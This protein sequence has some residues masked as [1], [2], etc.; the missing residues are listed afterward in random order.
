MLVMQRNSTGPPSYPRLQA[1]VYFTKLGGLGLF[2]RRRRGLEPALGGVR[3]YTD[4]ET[5][6]GSRLEIEI[7]LPDGTT[8]ICKV[9]VVRVELLPPG[10]PA[11]YDVGLC[12]IAIHPHDRER[13][14]PVLKQG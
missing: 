4:E 1:P 10:S 11:T 2:R 13:L 8:V 7:F 12:F 14:S 6:E 3:V 9:G 5:K